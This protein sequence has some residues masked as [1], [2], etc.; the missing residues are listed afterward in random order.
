MVDSVHDNF[1]NKAVSQPFRCSAKVCSD[2]LN[3]GGA[4][5]LKQFYSP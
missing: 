5:P 2:S 3:E 4:L 1:P